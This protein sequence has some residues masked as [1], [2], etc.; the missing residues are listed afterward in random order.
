MLSSDVVRVGDAHVLRGSV[1][2]DGVVSEREERCRL[3]SVP[4]RTALVAGSAPGIG[5]RVRRQGVACGF[6]A[7]NWLAGSVP[8]ICWRVRARARAGFPSAGDA[9]VV[10]APWLV[11]LV[12]R[13]PGGVPGLVGSDHA[14]AARRRRTMP[15]FFFF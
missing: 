3:F 13:E 14:V 9:V 6:G 12:P 7:R 8:G 1:G 11:G 10:A 4:G 2:L 5:W 15:S